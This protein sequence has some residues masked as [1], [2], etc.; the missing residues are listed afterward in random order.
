MSYLTVLRLVLLVVS[1]GTSP[2]DGS[3][4][5]RGQLRDIDENQ[6]EVD[7]GSVLIGWDQR[8]MRGG[9]EKQILRVLKKEHAEKDGGGEVTKDQWRMMGCDRGGGDNQNMNFF[10]RN[11]GSVSYSWY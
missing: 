3:S 7:A 1:T 10:D 2:C 8:D 4:L 9:N 6:A 11:F 5:R